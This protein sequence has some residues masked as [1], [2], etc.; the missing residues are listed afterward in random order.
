MQ[1]PFCGHELN[2]GDNYCSHCAAPVRTGKEQS[3]YLS[4]SLVHSLNSL[5]PDSVKKPVKELI[6]DLFLRLI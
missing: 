2:D 1:C 4:L 5:S 6:F 3:F